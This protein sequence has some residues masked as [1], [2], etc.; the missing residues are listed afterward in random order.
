MKTPIALPVLGPLMGLAMA[1]L[2]AYQLT[3]GDRAIDG[4]A[5]WIM[6]ACAVGMFSATLVCG[7]I[8]K[9]LRKRMGLL[10][11]LP[12]VALLSAI[13]ALGVALSI[14]IVP[15]WMSSY[16]IYTPLWRFRPVM[17]PLM[18]IPNGIG[19]A[20]IFLVPLLGLPGLILSMVPGFVVA[21]GS[22]EHMR[23]GSQPK[24]E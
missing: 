15:H 19:L 5:V 4:R 2:V 20:A 14:L 7:L 1:G 16:A 3:A 12:L 13:I 21:L 24:T 23:A 22:T 10:F 18:G 17:A 6:S 9:I 8:A 11:R